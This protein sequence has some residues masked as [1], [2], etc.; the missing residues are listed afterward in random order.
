MADPRDQFTQD[1]LPRR[2]GLYF[3]L[4]LQKNLQKNLNTSRLNFIG[5]NTYGIDKEEDAYSVTANN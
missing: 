5:V 2:I 1:L 3:M 4:I